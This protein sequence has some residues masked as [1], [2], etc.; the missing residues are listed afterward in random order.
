VRASYSI[1]I[2]IFFGAFQVS[3]AQTKEIDSL[4][5][6]LK[7]ATHDSTRCNILNVLIENEEDDKIWPLYN[8]QVKEIA[9]SNLNTIKK[10]SPLRLFF[11]R[12]LAGALNNIGYLEKFRGD[13]SKGLEY[14]HKSLKIYEQIGDRENMANA[15]NNIAFVYSEQ[16]DTTKA[17]TCFFKNLDLYNEIGNKY[18]VSIT[19]NN[20]GTIYID[21]GKLKDALKYFEMGLGIAEK[22]QNKR[23]IA[24]TLNNIGVV[25]S[26]SPDMKTSTESHLDIAL[27][28]FIKS[29]SIRE[30]TQDKRGMAISLQ[31]IAE[32]TMKKGNLADAQKYAERGL[33]LSKEIG[34]PDNIKRSSAVLSKVYS[35]TRNWE[36]AYNMQV[37]FHQMSDSL[38][39]ER[40]RKI[41]IQKGFQ[42]EYDKKVTAD[43][44]RG[45]E[46]RKV[47][48]AKLSEE[49]TQK[50]ALYCGI[51]LISLF[52][53]FM[54]NRLKVSKRQNQLI[55]KQKTELQRQK[56][57]VE[58]HQKETL[59]SIHYARRIQTALIANSDFISQHVKESFIYFNPKD[60]VSGDFY[61]ATTH[62]QKFYLAVCDSTGHGVP[63]AFMSLLNIGFLNEA[64]KEK[65]IE[66]PDEIFNYVRKRLIETISDGGQK[67]GMDGILMCVDKQNNK[68]EY[69]AA[70]N[71]PI[72]IRDNQIIELSKDKMP[73]GHGERS[74]PFTC[75]SLILE[76]NDIIY[77]YTDGFADQFGGPKGKKYKYKQLNEQLLKVHQSSLSEQKNVLESEFNNWKGDLEQIDDIC[78]IGLRV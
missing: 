1:Y 57:I 19:S 67:D 56:E 61:W 18:G 20:I 6:A 74:K 66:S 47:F 50:F 51:F 45:L 10:D 64:I 62:K 75:H 13:V 23:A 72:L 3:F 55:E 60:I 69:A 37:L 46:E 36:E 59:D 58:G 22:L 28:Y 21:Q 12:N 38:S 70:N 27:R 29:L 31:N 68:I 41:S 7:N 32:T 5:T 8:K 11:L 78:I 65:N 42:Y 71:E 43:S 24:Y 63:G 16:G 26:R 53:I 54:F 73:V 30:E 34:Y 9:E 35:K 48:D 17:L 49:K 4:K 15:F 77:L 44:V 25:Y 39:N 40:N 33:Q 2:I 52:G 76:P 14:Y